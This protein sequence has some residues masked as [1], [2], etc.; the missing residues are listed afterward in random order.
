MPILICTGLSEYGNIWKARHLGK[1]KT[2]FE[3]PKGWTSLSTWIAPVATFQHALAPLLWCGLISEVRT[4]FSVSSSFIREVMHA[5][6]HAVELHGYQDCPMQGSS[7]TARHDSQWILREP[8]CSWLWCCLLLNWPLALLAACL[9]HFCPDRESIEPLQQRWCDCQSCPDADVDAIGRINPTPSKTYIVWSI[10]LLPPLWAYKTP[11]SDPLYKYITLLTVRWA[12]WSQQAQSTISLDGRK[13]TWSCHC[14][15]D[16]CYS[17]GNQESWL[18]VGVCIVSFWNTEKWKNRV[19]Q[20]SIATKP[21][22]C[23]A[24]GR[25][26]LKPWQHQMFV[27][28][29][30]VSGADAKK[31]SRLVRSW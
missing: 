19:L 31:L 13:N 17:Q 15:V 20:F 28:V 11:V 10:I 9:P 8:G 6:L 18:V 1:A 5:L 21:R 25:Q 27:S 26:V 23:V 2:I 22:G 12:V 29:C 30:V 24:A 14:P 16:V 3:V 7:L 4:S